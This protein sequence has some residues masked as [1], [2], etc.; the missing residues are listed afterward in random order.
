[1]TLIVAFGCSDG[2]VLSADS[3]SSEQDVGTKQEVSEKIRRVGNLPI[4]YGGS[5]DVGLLQKIDEGVQAVQI[6]QG[7]KL[8]RLRQDL[9]PIIGA[10]QR[11]AL[12]GH[13]PYPTA[14]HQA[15]PG[16]WM[17]F[18]GVVD[19]MPF[20]LEFQLNNSDTV[21][22]ADYGHFA[23]IGGGKGLAQALFRPHLHRFKE[24]TISHAAIFAQ[25]IIEDAVAISLSGLALP[26]R[27]WT[28]DLDGDVKILDDAE[29]HAAS[30]SADAWRELEREALGEFIAAEP[31][32]EE[33][34]PVP[35]P[36]QL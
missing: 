4:V 13:V 28:I 15:P 2:V 26:V 14:A 34:V 35:E 16:A 24:R 10:E 1:M 27:T 23:A 11:A 25:R 8:K 18:A 32:G 33:P 31:G 6:R 21:Y 7:Q 19:R 29:V 3:A 20:I 36:Q 22:G 9:K 5:G 12:D 30:V 17:L